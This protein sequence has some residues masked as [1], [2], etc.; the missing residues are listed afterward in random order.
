MPGTISTASPA[1]RYAAISSL[2]RATISGSPPLSRT[3]R[4]PCL[5]SLIVSAWTSFGCANENLLCLAAREIQHVARDQIVEQNDVGR[6]QRAHRAQRQQ[7]RIAGTGAD[8]RHRAVLGGTAQTFDFGEEALK[9]VLGWRLLRMRDRVCGEQLPE[10]AAAR[11]RQTR[12]LHGAAPTRSRRGPLRKS[13]RQQGFELGA[14]RLGKHR[15]RAVGGNADHQRRAVDDGAERKVAERRL[16]DHVHRHAGGASGSGEFCGGLVIRRRRRPRA[17]RREDR[18]AA[19][20]G[21]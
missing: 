11:E 3:T 18:L 14:D 13:P 19:M 17:S 12:C 2:D 9:R 4:W 8:Q 10:L 16:V 7:L 6:L 5:A 20:R 1:A 15:R 21:R